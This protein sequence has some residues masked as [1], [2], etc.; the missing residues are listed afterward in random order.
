MRDIH[1]IFK[2][3]T[4]CLIALLI[5]G[6]SAFQ[7]KKIIEGPQISIVSPANGATVHDSLI[8]VTGIAKNIKEITVNDRTIYIDEQGNFK[9]K[10]LLYPGYNIIKLEA[11]DKFG[12]EKNKKIDI[13]LKEN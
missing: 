12:K 7:A 11:K 13:V 9:E 2:I 1:S 8:Y 10:M 4:I 5:F 3:G 6:Y